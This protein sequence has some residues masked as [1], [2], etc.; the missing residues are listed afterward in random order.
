M[1]HQVMVPAAQ[2]APTLLGTMDLDTLGEALA[3]SGVC[4]DVGLAT[5]RLR[6]DVPTL[7]PA[8]R[9]AYRA[10]AFVA[11][12]GFADLHIE[13][14]RPAG[15]RRWLRP[16]AVFRSDG[17]APFEP[18]PAANALPLVEWGANWLIGQRMNHVLLLHAAALVK[19]GCAL[20]MPAVPGSGKSTLAAALSLRGWRLLSDEFGAWDAASATFRACSSRWR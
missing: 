8:L 3:E 18:F 9:A 5:L 16:Q 10:H 11:S 6:S 2:T 7:A 1:A 4:I 17:N 14:V 19:D 20:L 12:T 13:I 15:L